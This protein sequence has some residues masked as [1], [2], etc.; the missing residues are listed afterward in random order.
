MGG[1]CRSFSVARC[2]GSTKTSRLP[3]ALQGDPLSSR[4]R[5]GEQLG[6]MGNFSWVY[7][8]SP[9]LYPPPP[10]RKKWQFSVEGPLERRKISAG[11]FLWVL[12]EPGRDLYWPLLLPP[13]YSGRPEDEA[14]DEDG[15]PLQDFYDS[16]PPG[17]G[18]PASALRDAYALYYPA[19]KRYHPRGLRYGPGLRWREGQGG[20]PPNMLFFIKALKPLFFLA[21]TRESDRKLVAGRSVWPQGSRGT[22][23]SVAQGV[24]GSARPSQTPCLPSLEGSRNS[25]SRQ[26]V[27]GTSQKSNLRVLCP[28]GGGRVFPSASRSAEAHACSA[29]GLGRPLGDRVSDPGRSLCLPVR[30]VAQGILNKAYRKVLDQ[31]SA[32]K[33]L[34]TL[35]A[36][37]QG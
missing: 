6:G 37:S 16:D 14:Y 31:L 4:G 35:V 8:L 12:A 11:P 20:G 29:G 25:G 24:A 17:V 30:D 26:S 28:G 27:A 34:Q 23:R 3:R 32:R 7:F 21:G 5:I 18:S 33:Y 13:G 9:Y 10:S 36:K 22:K 19:E 2:T 1:G 15:N